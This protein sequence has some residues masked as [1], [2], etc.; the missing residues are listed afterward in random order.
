M[1]D[2]IDIS[3]L[4]PPEVLQALYNAARPQGLGHFDPAGRRQMTLDEARI[5]VGTH[6]IA[7]RFDYVQG[8]VMKVELDGTSFDPTLFDRDNGEGAA[9]EA[10]ALITRERSQ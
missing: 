2:M 8:R 6:G 5:I 1:T 10:I 7:E 4:S 3:H 9:A